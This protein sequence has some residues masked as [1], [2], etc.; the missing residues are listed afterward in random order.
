MIL[1]FLQFQIVANH[2]PSKN[3]KQLVISHWL[4]R[5]EKTERAC[6]HVHL[7]ACARLSFLTL[8][9]SGLLFKHGSLL[10][11]NPGES[12]P[13]RWMQLLVKPSVFGWL[14]RLQKQNKSNSELEGANANGHPTE[15]CK[16][17]PRSKLS[18]K[19]V[20]SDLT[21]WGWFWQTNSIWWAWAEDGTFIDQAITPP[22]PEGTAGTI[23]QET[24][25]FE[26]T[27]TY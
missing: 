8:T 25:Q 3:L 12:T 2:C 24:Y 21:D 19:H 14:C 6:I 5:T 7:P 9:N 11:L 1:L 20:I 22:S 17:V 23:S 13:S 15:G 16:T 18:Y 27:Q 4:T 26:L 10:D